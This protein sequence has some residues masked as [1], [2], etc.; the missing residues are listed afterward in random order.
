MVPR[1]APVVGGDLTVGL[2]CGLQICCVAR[3][4]AAGCFSGCTCSCVPRL[5]VLFVGVAGPDWNTI[6]GLGGSG[7]L[8][9][10]MW[11]YDLYLCVWRSL[12]SWPLS[13]FWSGFCCTPYFWT[14]SA[15]VV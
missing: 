14:G 15:A 13:C 5:G 3:V 6:R 7:R 11:A 1:T 8:F 12:I 4:L 2:C 10:H 9:A